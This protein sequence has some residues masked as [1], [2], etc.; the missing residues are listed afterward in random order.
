LED[1]GLAGFVALVVAEYPNDTMILNSMVPKEFHDVVNL[2]SLPKEKASVSLLLQCAQLEVTAYLDTRYIGDKIEEKIKSYCE[3][4]YGGIKV[5]YVP[6]EDPLLGIGGMGHAFGR[7]RRESERITCALIEN[8]SSHSMSVLIHVD[9]RKYGDFISDVIKGH[10]STNFNIAHFGFSRQTISR[11][12][13]SYRNC[14]TDMSSLTSFMI[15]EPKSYK[16][17]IRRYQD[18]ILFGSDAIIGYH[19]AI[20]E[21]QQFLADFLGDPEL[22][23]KV[24]YKN[25]L[26]F[27]NS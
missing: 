17:F 11:F 10:P 27:H 16:E 2:N 24:F 9:L 22:S 13:E 1:I 6:E 26:S 23:E 15:R 14:Y 7:A 5:L 4:G 25:Y 8:A 21:A 18:K 20:E 19:A 3:L 12:L